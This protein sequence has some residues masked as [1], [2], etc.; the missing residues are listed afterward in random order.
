MSEVVALR[1]VVL[2]WQHRP[3][4]KL[5]CGFTEVERASLREI[6]R[7]TVSRIPTQTDGE[8]SFIKT[9]VIG[10]GAD[11]PFLSDQRRRMRILDEWFVERRAVLA[12]HELVMGN[13]LASA[14]PE[15]EDLFDL[16]NQSTDRL[17]PLERFGQH[18][19]RTQKAANVPNSTTQVT[20]CI[21]KLEKSI[22][23]LNSGSG[24]FRGEGGRDDVE[25]AWTRV[26]VEEMIH[27]MNIA[28]LHIR[29]IRRVFSSAVV[30]KWLRFAAQY[31][32][33]ERFE[34]VSHFSPI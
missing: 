34:S 33:L 5:R 6:Q 32:F 7:S 9:R 12:V 10:D 18:I 19:I 31:D 22:G 16:S 28:F 29:S 20:L 4:T 11:T 23:S 27:V 21:E 25:D 2:E 24:L 14:P 13:V 15:I 30:L 8:F 3:T 17:P 1:L 26:H